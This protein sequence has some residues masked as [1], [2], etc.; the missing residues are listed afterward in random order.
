M[1]FHDTFFGKLKTFA[2]NR[3]QIDENFY[4]KINKAWR[5]RKNKENFLKVLSL[6]AKAMEF[7]EWKPK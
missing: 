6:S 2:E 4:T 3:R 7:D 1:S 5:S